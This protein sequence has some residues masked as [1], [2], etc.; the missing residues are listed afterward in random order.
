MKKNLLILAALSV[1]A[2]PF[3]FS[4][5]KPNDPDKPADVIIMQDPPTKDAA[6]L[7]VFPA[8]NLPKYEDSQ[9]KYEIIQIEFTEASRYLLKRRVIATKANVGDIETVIGS[10]TESGGNYNCQGFGSVNVSGS[11]SNANVNVKPDGSEN[12]GNEYSGNANVQVTTPPSGQGQKNASR[13]WKID[14]M[15]LNVSGSVTFSHDF[16]GCNL[17]DIANYAKGENVSINP[18]D[19]KGYK[20]TEFCFTGNETFAIN[21]ENASDIV[22]TYKINETAKT[23]SF[24]LPEGNKFFSGSINGSYEYPADKKMNLTLNAS[25]KGYNG[26]MVFYMSQN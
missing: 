26:S 20:V 10:Y 3:L 23:I 22:G 11:G 7:V 18:D 21:F 13:N 8:E 14:A 15:T 16:T 6:K 24:S 25:I 1:V 2:L 17:Y 12:K 4:C 9:A 5:G 19:Y